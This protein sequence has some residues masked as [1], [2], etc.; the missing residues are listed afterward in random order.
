MFRVSVSRA[1]GPA[2]DATRL[3]PPLADDRPGDA[4]RLLPP[5]ADDNIELANN[6]NVIG[7]QNLVEAIEEFFSP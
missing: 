1:V 6:V 5:L 2:G 7:T 4:T 3:L